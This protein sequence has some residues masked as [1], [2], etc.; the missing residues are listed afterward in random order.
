MFKRS[1]K[2]SSCAKMW[3]L[4][5][6]KLTYYTLTGFDLTTHYSADGDDTTRP[7]HQGV[8]V[9]F[10][11]LVVK[12][13]P[14]ELNV[15]GS[16]PGWV[17]GGSLLSR[18]CATDLD[19]SLFRGLNVFG[20]TRARAWCGEVGEGVR[21]GPRGPATGQGDDPKALRAKSVTLDCKKWDSSPLQKCNPCYPSFFW[22]HVWFAH[23]N[24]LYRALD[25]KEQ[26]A[27]YLPSCLAN[28]AVQ[29]RFKI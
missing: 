21:G 8:T 4:F 24:C 2:K 20:R 1:R 16:N 5:F 25:N 22:N 11:G 23:G 6:K 3:L 15:A 17:K 26:Y 9:P 14:E 29:A 27:D 7:R 12:S 28:L 18:K 19:S 13:P 10:S